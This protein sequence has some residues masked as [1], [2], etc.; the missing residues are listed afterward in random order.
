MFVRQG[1]GVITGNSRRFHRVDSIAG[2][3]SGKNSYQ[4]ALS[5]QADGSAIAVTFIKHPLFTSSKCIGYAGKCSMVIES[6]K[7]IEISVKEPWT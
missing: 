2:W 3:G 7:A 1:M 5:G 4:Q 6:S